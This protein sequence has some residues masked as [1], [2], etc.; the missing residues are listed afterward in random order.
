MLTSNGSNSPKDLACC[1]YS[2][3]DEIKNLQREWDAFVETVGGDIYLTFDWCRVWWQYYG[4]ERK[5]II[6]IYRDG[7]RIVAI[8]PLFIETVWLGPIWLRIVKIVGSDYTM[9][10]LNPPV[11]VEY[12]ESIFRDMLGYLNSQFGYDALW[13]GPLSEAPSACLDALRSVC[14]RAD[15]GVCLLQE[16]IRSPYTEFT[17]PATFEEY[18]NSLDKR[19]RGNYRRD[20]NLLH[21]MFQV[22]TC[23][24]D[25]YIIDEMEAFRRLHEQQWESEGKLGH[26]RDWPK[27]YEF[28]K[29]L[30]EA[31]SDKGRY[32]LV[33]LKANSET[34][35]YQLCYL[36]GKTLY[37]RL[38]A[39]T[40]GSEWNRY[41]LGRTGLISMIEWAIGQGIQRI[42]AGAGHYDYKI[43][44]GGQE[45]PLITILIARNRLWSRLRVCIFHILSEWLHLFYYRIWFNRIAAKLPFKRRPLWGLWIRTRL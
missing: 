16:K 26:F 29:S 8:L 41:G 21:K 36:L 37:W 28:N 13:L 34:V 25:Q 18:L 6:R 44:A 4:K 40:S 11:Q 23:V 42:E 14:G 22:E 3:F 15:S 20:M 2:S 31:H 32:R 19:Q 27:G 17:L 43:K 39:R 24:Q 9:A 10:M 35:S 30:V 45:H 33:C 7:Q 12:A 38:P 1:T 5:L